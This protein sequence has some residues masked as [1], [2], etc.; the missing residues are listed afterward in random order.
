MSSPK[1]Q[2]I[3]GAMTANQEQTSRH[4]IPGTEIFDM[5]QTAHITK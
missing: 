1:V 4:Q 5:E 3:Y 2:N